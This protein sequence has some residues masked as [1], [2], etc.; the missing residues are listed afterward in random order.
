MSAGLALCLVFAGSGLRVNSAAALRNAPPPD[1]DAA[2]GQLV[3]TRCGGCHGINTL[4]QHPQDAAGWAQT[5]A[6][7][8]KL[9]AQLAPP[10]KSEIVAYLARHFG[11]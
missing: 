2:I 9:G 4:S 11:G 6:A 7:M 10:E 1:A 8:Q 3:L 5:V